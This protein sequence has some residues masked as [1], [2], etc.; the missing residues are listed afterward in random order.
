MDRAGTA[1]VRLL[2]RLEQNGDRSDVAIPLRALRNAITA[3]Y[4]SESIFVARELCEMLFMLFDRVEADFRSHQCSAMIGEE[5]RGRMFKLVAGETWEPYPELKHMALRRM[6]RYLLNERATAPRPGAPGSSARRGALKFF[7]HKIIPADK[8][9]WEACFDDLSRVSSAKLTML[10]KNTLLAL[11]DSEEMLL[12][13]TAP[14]GPSLA[15]PEAEASDA[16]ADAPAE[17]PAARAHTGGDLIDL[18]TGV[19]IHDAPAA[20]QPPPF[21]PLIPPPPTA[22]TTAEA[23]GGGRPAPRDV[24]QLDQAPPPR[25]VD[26]AALPAGTAP[27]WAAPRPPGAKSGNPFLDDA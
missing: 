16:P 7:S 22:E 5:L 2:S 9:S 6:F 3:V 12:A 11:A 10:L 20:P 19:T 8:S 17:P 24:A 27:T 4:T 14:P 25:A 26:L 21:V 18:L 1:F 15:P 13:A 23:N